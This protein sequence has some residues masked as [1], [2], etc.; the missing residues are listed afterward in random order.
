MSDAITFQVDVDD[1]RAR[2]SHSTWAAPRIAELGLPVRRV[3]A[4][5]CAQVERKHFQKRTMPPGAVDPLA[6]DRMNADWLVL[7][8]RAFC[9][10]REERHAFLLVTGIGIEALGR[11]PVVVHF[12]VVPQ[13]DLRYVCGARAQMLVLVVVGVIAAEV[14]EGLGDS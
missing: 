5:I 6:L 13:H 4:A 7:E 2:S 3:G 12:M 11:V 10:R 1:A 14:G 9:A 8:E